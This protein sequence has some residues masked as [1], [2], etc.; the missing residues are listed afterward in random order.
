MAG[1]DAAI[2]DRRGWRTLLLAAVPALGVIAVLRYQH[3]LAVGPAVMLALVVVAG[4]A[5]ALKRRIT[6]EAAV[7]RRLE[8]LANNARGQL[9]QLAAR[10]AVADR[11]FD[12]LPGPLYL[13][14]AEG[15]VIRANRAAREINGYDPQG[16]DFGESIRHPDLVKAVINV[17]ATGKAQEVEITLPVPVERAYLAQIEPV[18]PA[19]DKRYPENGPALLVALQ[20]VTL[21]LRSERMRADFVANVSH[22][23]RTPLTSLIGFIET[24]RGPAAEDAEARDKFLPIMQEQ[25][26]RMYRLIA[27]LLSLSRIEMDE[28]TKPTGKADI[29]QIVGKVSDML[30]LKTEKKQMR[31]VTEIDPELARVEGDEDQLTQVFQNLMDNAVKYGKPGTDVTVRLVPRED[32]RIAVSVI[33]RGD[34]IPENHLSRLT[35]RFYRVDAARSRELGGTGLGL[36]I[37]KHIVNRHRGRLTIASEEGKGSSFTVTLPRRQG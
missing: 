16:R 26:E 7:L 15:T 23:L 12:T 28:H 19:G 14:D 36:A 34:G 11:I 3:M 25:A 30:S 20:D 4:I 21:V 17:L 29:A 24:L 37:V 35:E 32:G 9:D 22:E 8:V 18:D 31:I 6:T 2:A 1:S 5:F 10:S 33:D 27:D 13:L